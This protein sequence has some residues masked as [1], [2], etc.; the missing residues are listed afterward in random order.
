MLKAENALAFLKT[1]GVSSVSFDYAL[2]YELYD[3]AVGLT[4]EEVEANESPQLLNPYSY[5]RKFGSCF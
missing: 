4:P 2:S 1:S 3:E 5:A